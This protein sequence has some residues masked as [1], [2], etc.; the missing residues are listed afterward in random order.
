MAN[1]MNN[2]VEGIGVTNF[3]DLPVNPIYFTEISIPEIVCIPEEKPDMEQL[4]S[5]MVDTEI[6]S[7][8]LIKTPVG[9]SNEGQILTGYKLIVEILLRQKIKYVA[10]EPT[11]SVHAAHFDKLMSSIFIVVP[12]S[13]VID[14]V[15]YNIEDLFEQGR[16]IVTPYIEDIF[17][18]QKDKRC[19]FKNITILVD[20][21]PI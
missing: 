15:T 9:T 8:R 2:F 3:I 1:T 17:A 16:L 21:K 4:I 18:E 19:V 5:V 11:Q 14:G 13:I 6:A 10:D 7:T 12:V 20:V